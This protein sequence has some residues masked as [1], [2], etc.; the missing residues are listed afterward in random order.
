MSTIDEQIEQFQKQIRENPED[1]LAHYNLGYTLQGA[2]RKNEAIAEY[3]KALELDINRNYSAIVNYNLGTIHYR[4]K[5]LEEAIAEFGQTIENLPKLIAEEDIK[6]NVATRAHY[7][8]GCALL[9]KT[10]QR[11]RYGNEESD[12]ERVEE[13]FRKALEFDPNFSSAQRDLKTVKGMI[14]YGWNVHDESGALL[15]FFAGRSD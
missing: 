9:D 3:R 7:N 15:K 11:E 6:S 14:K 4:D 1:I 8:L 2:G 13:H 5:K 10:Q 12:L